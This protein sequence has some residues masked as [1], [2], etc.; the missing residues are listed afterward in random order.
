MKSHC[1]WTQKGITPLKPERNTVQPAHH[2]AI[3]RRIIRTFIHTTFPVRNVSPTA[4]RSF[5][6]AHPEL[7]LRLPRK[8]KSSGNTTCRLLR[9]LPVVTAPPAVARTIAA[10]FSALIVTL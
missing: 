10:L 1:P 9:G 7:H 2:G 8:T 4:T 3:P 6:P 5:V